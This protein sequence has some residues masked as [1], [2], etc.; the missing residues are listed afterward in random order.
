MLVIMDTDI[1]NSAPVMDVAPPPAPETAEAPVETHE[2]PKADPKKRVPPIPSQAEPKSGVA[3]AIVA[4][5]FIVISLAGLATYA[6]LQ[7]K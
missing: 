6:Y 3:L 7:Q 2:E 1:K 4:T 5:V